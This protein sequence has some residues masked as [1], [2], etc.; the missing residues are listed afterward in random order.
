MENVENIEYNTEIIEIQEKPD[1]KELLENINSSIGTFFESA[2]YSKLTKSYE[3]KEIRGFIKYLEHL[4]KRIG[5]LTID[6]DEEQITI[7]V[8]EEENNEIVKILSKCIEKNFR[9]MENEK[10]NSNEQEYIKISKTIKSLIDNLIKEINKQLTMRNKDISDPDIDICNEK[11]SP[12]ELL[13]KMPDDIKKCTLFI[14]QNPLYAEYN[15]EQIE[16]LLLQINLIKNNDIEAIKQYI[17]GTNNFKKSD[18]KVNDILKMFTWKLLK[19]EK[20]IKDPNNKKF[21]SNKKNKKNINTYIKNIEDSLENLENEIK[22]QV[23]II[24]EYRCK[25]S[26]KLMIE[27]SLTNPM[28]KNLLSFKFGEQNEEK[29]VFSE[30]ELLEIYKEALKILKKEVKNLKIQEDEERKELKKQLAIWGKKL[31]ETTNE[32]I[33]E[34]EERIK[35]EYSKQN[36][37]LSKKLYEKIKLLDNINQIIDDKKQNFQ[38]KENIQQSLKEEISQQNRWEVSSETTE[39]S[40]EDLP[41]G[42]LLEGNSLEGDSQSVISDD[43]SDHE[44]NFQNAEK[45]R[46]KN[47]L[48]TI[49]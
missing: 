33:D 31:L 41:E 42:D 11:L 13:Q 43:F 48:C 12:I 15:Q 20:Y 46:K 17:R 18:Y 32:G 38:T 3:V 30:E 24:F 35:Q 45:Y 8:Q 1:I 5:N 39:L 47:N 36:K 27:T 6:T 40:E 29:S 10:N 9:T 16:N 2:Q 26:Q 34:I 49:L 21:I 19:I 14:K 28:Y 4:K 37:L 25:V 44:D 23:K 7:E 22:Q